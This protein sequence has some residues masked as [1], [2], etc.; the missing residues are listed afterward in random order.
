M[1]LEFSSFRPTRVYSVYIEGSEAIGKPAQSEHSSESHL[2][3]PWF[4]FADT[5]SDLAFKWKL[6]V[7]L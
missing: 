2:G 3:V 7:F 1:L 4:M 6:L 5:G